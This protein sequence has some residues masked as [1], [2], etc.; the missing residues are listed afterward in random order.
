MSRNKNMNK[1]KRQR[2]KKRQ[3]KDA[4][5]PNQSSRAASAKLIQK[6]NP[7]SRLTPEI[8]TNIC[9]L[10]FPTHH[11]LQ[12]VFEVDGPAIIHHRWKDVYNLSLVDRRCR[13]IISPFLYRCIPIP[14]PR[15]LT[16][17]LSFVRFVT[18]KPTIAQGIKQLYLQLEVVKSGVTLITQ[19]DVKWVMKQAEETGTPFCE[20]KWKGLP[21]KQEFEWKGTK[22]A[23]GR[24][25]ERP[26]K[27]YTDEV[28]TRNW[29][30]CQRMETLL[31]IL[32]RRLPDL[33]DLGLEHG[34]RV[35]S[36]AYT[37]LENQR[38][39]AG[40][41]KRQNL[42]PVPPRVT[43]P[44]LPTVRSVA[45]KI[46][47][48]ATEWQHV[49]DKDVRILMEMCLKAERL[50]VEELKPVGRLMPWVNPNNPHLLPW[51]HSVRKL[52]L[53]NS[54]SVDSWKEMAAVAL[55]IRSCPVLEE[56]RFM[57]K[58]RETRE[59]T[60]HR[61]RV[62][63]EAMLFLE[64]ALTAMH[65]WCLRTLVLDLRHC[66]QS[67]RPPA[68]GR[69]R[70]YANLKHIYLNLGHRIPQGSYGYRDRN[71]MDREAT[72]V[73]KALPPCVRVARLAGE[74]WLPKPLKRLI[75]NHKRVPY[76]HDIEVEGGDDSDTLEAMASLQER[77]AQCGTGGGQLRSPQSSKPVVVG[78]SAAKIWPRPVRSEWRED[79]PEIL[80][81]TNRETITYGTRKYPDPGA[82]LVVQKRTAVTAPSKTEMPMPV[83]LEW[84]H[85]AT[86]PGKEPTLMRT[87][88]PSETPMAIWPNYED[89]PRS[90]APFTTSHVIMA[91]A[92]ITDLPAELIDN[93]LD[94]A[95]TE[96]PEDTAIESLGPRRVA[97]CPSIVRQQ[98]INSL[99]PTCRRFHELFRHEQHR[100]IFLTKKNIFPRMVKLHR[101]L[102]AT[103]Q[104]QVFQNTT[105]FVVDYDEDLFLA[106]SYRDKAGYGK[107][108]N[109]LDS[110]KGDTRRA[111]F[112]GMDE[113]WVPLDR[114][115]RERVGPHVPLQRVHGHRLGLLAQLILLRLPNVEG[116]CL[117]YCMMDLLQPLDVSSGMTPS[118]CGIFAKYGYIKDLL[119]SDLQTGLPPA[120]FIAFSWLTRL[121]L[122]HCAVIDPNH[123]DQALKRL[124][125]L[126]TFVYTVKS[127]PTPMWPR[128]PM[129]EQYL[130][131]RFPETLTTLCI[132]APLDYWFGRCG[133]APVFGGLQKLENLWVN[134][135]NLSKSGLGNGRRKAI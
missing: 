94:L 128:C 13:T 71:K 43:L 72:E 97:D 6:Q 10:L 112:K 51:L 68:W 132:D 21:H 117:P 99:A 88:M 102:G 48:S 120:E 20:R 134:T 49:D 15:S 4:Q 39:D 62:P 83:W 127:S 100:A 79:A 109:K 53:T 95:T 41:R 29:D 54:R 81:W 22:R 63:Q 114:V 77:F 64:N 42:P 110:L 45:M 46:N 103:P 37:A 74:F 130:A 111:G 84:M 104:S 33:V 85:P 50:S 118:R 5:R 27:Q 23:Q 8:L 16:K 115:G 126:Q 119:T 25:P 12:D 87:N 66:T 122:W 52:T 1:N 19:D 101:V 58:Y 70:E 86:Q 78:S 69:L 14:G 18:D 47:R 40:D 121:V 56:F 92:S 107:I 17:L 30:E 57:A 34:K 36:H 2:I 61:V 26:M 9:S 32:L 67:D 55:Y 131:V 116:V 76:L 7:F 60:P 105:Q 44:T 98:I 28:E 75:R 91:M 123:L 82:K 24:V 135:H 11:N 133:L 125:R 129:Y 96:V 89:A 106:K 80:R 108:A 59:G 90:T 35:F 31:L 3:N 73:L 113:Y 65:F 124:N 38:L 93:I